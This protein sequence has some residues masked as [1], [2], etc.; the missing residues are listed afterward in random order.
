[1]SSGVQ[2]ENL[3]A[4]PHEDSLVEQAVAGDEVSL[5]LLLTE[6]RGPLCR[7]VAG[8]IPRDLQRIAAADDIVQEAHTEVF[9]RITSFEPRG[10]ESFHRWVATIAVR[11]L[12]SAIRDHRTAKRG[13]GRRV[14]APARNMENSAITL[15]DLLATAGVTPSRSVA[16]R[17]AV[18]AMQTALADLPEQYRQAIWLVHI[19]GHPVKEVAVEM[20]RTQRA[21]HGLC[22][23]GIAQ[24]RERLGSGSKF[25][26]SSG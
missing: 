8:K 3:R 21:I 24:M 17:E 5:T 11:R 16:R 7:L 20:G 22:R 18:A 26:T 6:S 14:A 9:R 12:R 1:M 2:N 23:R 10:G 13:G 19:E 4:H 15:L 25:L